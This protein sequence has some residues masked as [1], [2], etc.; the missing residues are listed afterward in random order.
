MPERL[1]DS[2]RAELETLGVA[3][4]TLPVTRNWAD[5]VG[6]EVARNAWPARMRGDGTLVVHARSSVWAF[7]LNQLAEQIRPRLTPTPVGLRF[8]VGKVPEPVGP[9]P[10]EPVQKPSSQPDPA[11]VEAAAE[12][13]GG[14][15][16]Q[17][18]REALQRA[19]TLG[20]S[21][22]RDDRPM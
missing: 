8:I 19:V 10:A 4:R 11:A 5:A 3:D 7:E 20:L 18:V 9:E 2:V 22:R 13:A 17:D 12:L 21:R 16:S 6:P 14:V 1:G 15:S